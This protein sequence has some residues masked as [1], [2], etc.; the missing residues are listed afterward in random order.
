M[1][2]Q[3]HPGSTMSTPLNNIP[4]NTQQQPTNVKELEDP[5]VQDVLREFEEEIAASKNNHPQKPMQPPQQLMQPSQQPIQPPPQQ[6]MQPQQQPQAQYYPTFPSDKIDKKI[7]DFN[8]MKN[9]LI[10]SIVSILLSYLGLFDFVYNKLPES[11]NSLVKNYDLIIKLAT[12]FLIYYFLIYYD[13][14]H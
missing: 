4:L 6:P 11:I 1:A 14:I 10:I 3:Q 13:I 12:S 5:M 7:L 2:T 8:L 9:A